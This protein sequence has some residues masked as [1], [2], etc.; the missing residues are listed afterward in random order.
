M[1]EKISVQDFASRIKQKYPQYSEIEDSVLV[2]KMLE[3]YPQYKSTV[4]TKEDSFG[5]TVYKPTKQEGYTI[6]PKKEEAGFFERLGGSAVEKPM[7]LAGS[8]VASTAAQ[9]GEAVEAPFRFAMGSPGVFKSLQSSDPNLKDKIR[10]YRHLYKKRKSEGAPAEELKAIE[11]NLSAIQSDFREKTSSIS[12]D[13]A[14]QGREIGKKIKAVNYTDA[15][16][17]SD[18]VTALEKGDG[19]A[20][21]ESIGSVLLDIG[22]QAT[23]SKLTGGA[24]LYLQGVGETYMESLDELEQRGMSADEAL[25]ETNIMLNSLTTG[26]IIG[27]LESL[28]IESVLGKLNKTFGNRWKNAAAKGI[29]GMLTEAPTEGLQEIAQIVGVTATNLESMNEWDRLKMI[30]KALADPKSTHRVLNSIILGGLGGKV[31][32][33]GAGVL[34]APSKTK[35]EA[36]TDKMSVKEEATE[37]KSDQII[38]DATKLGVV[39]ATP[40]AAEATE[41]VDNTFEQVKEEIKSKPT[42]EYSVEELTKEIEAIEEQTTKESTST[43]PSVRPKE[44]K[45]EIYKERKEEKQTLGKPTKEGLTEEVDVGDIDFGIEVGE[46]LQ[47]LKDERSRLKGEL[48]ELVDLERTADQFLT[49]KEQERVK[50]LKGTISKIEERIGDFKEPKEG[51]LGKPLTETKEAPERPTLKAVEEINSEKGLEFTSNNYERKVKRAL[52]RKTITEEERSSLEGWVK[53]YKEDVAK[54]QKARKPQIEKKIKER[55]ELKKK[56]VKAK[57]IEQYS[58]VSIRKYAKDEKHPK[59]KEANEFLVKQAE[60]KAKKAAEKQSKVVPE[61][62]LGPAEPL[63]QKKK[64]V[65]E[66]GPIE[67]STDAFKTKM[68]T[69]SEHSNEKGTLNI[70]SYFDKAS[71]SMSSDTK[72]DQA[73]TITPEGD[74]VPIDKV[75]SPYLQRIWNLGIGTAQSDS[76]AQSDHHIKEN[77]SNKG[78]VSFVKDEAKNKT[79]SKKIKKYVSGWNKATNS[80]ETINLLEAIGEE[81]GF[82]VKHLEVFFKPALTLSLP[83]GLTDSQVKAK[84]KALTE[85]LEK[86]IE[87][88]PLQKYLDLKPKTSSERNTLKEAKS[89]QTARDQAKGGKLAEATETLRKTT[90]SK[91][92]LEEAQPTLIRE[93]KAAK[94]ELKEAKETE[95]KAQT[96]EVYDKRED[97]RKKYKAIREEEET[98]GKLTDKRDAELTRLEK[99]ETKEAEVST[100]RGFIGTYSEKVEFENAR[101]KEL[102][103]VQDVHTATK[104]VSGKRTTK[105]TKKDVINAIEALNDFLTDRGRRPLSKSDRKNLAETGNLEGDIIRS[106]EEVKEANDKALKTII[107]TS[108]ADKDSKGFKKAQEDSDGAPLE[109]YFPSDDFNNDGFQSRSDQS[110]ASYLGIDTPIK[111]GKQIS[112]AEFIDKYIKNN[113]T[114][115]NVFSS[116]IEIFKNLDK[117]LGR[118]IFILE[119]DDIGG[120][121]G[122]YT[123]SNQG[124]H[125]IAIAKSSIKETGTHEVVHYLTTAIINSKFLENQLLDAGYSKEQLGDIRDIK[126]KVSQ[127]HVEASGVIKQAYDNL[128]KK[129]KN[130]TYFAT[131]LGKINFINEKNALIDSVTE[132][133]YADYLL[134]KSL[135]K[136]IDKYILD[137]KAFIRALVSYSLNQGATG[138]ESYHFTSSVY[139]TT[140]MEEFLAE[141]FSN[142]SFIAI[143]N[144]IG[145]TENTKKTSVY[146]QLM[147]YMLD[148][149]SK[150]TGISRKSL[151]RF[152]EYSFAG[153]VSDTMADYAKIMSKPY[154]ER[155]RAVERI[156]PGYE[157]NRGFLDLLFN[158]AEDSK[159][160]DKMSEEITEN[161][162]KLA[163]LS[164]GKDGKKV[165]LNLERV[166]RLV[167]FIRSNDP[168]FN[169]LVNIV[170]KINETL[171]DSKKITGLEVKSAYKR[172]ISNKKSAAKRKHKTELAKIKL[173]SEI[174]LGQAKDMIAEYIGKKIPSYAGYKRKDILRI[175]N[176]IRLVEDP[177]KF[178][179]YI[180]DI[181]RI[182]TDFKYDKALDNAKKAQNS[183]RTFVRSRLPIPEK[184][185][186]RRFKSVELELLSQKELED[187]KELVRILSF[188]KKKIKNPKELEEWQNII[189]DIKSFM[190]NYEAIKQESLKSEEKSSKD[191]KT[192][193]QLQEESN[194][195]IGKADAERNISM[196]NIGRVHKLAEAKAK[197]VLSNKDLSERTRELIESFINIIKQTSE[198]R[199]L[200]TDDL[201]DYAEGLRYF[202]NYGI[203]TE[204]AGSV[205]SKVEALVRVKDAIHNLKG[206]ELN[207]AKGNFS[208][209]MANANTAAQIVNFMAKMNKKFAQALNNLFFA[210]IRELDSKVYE[211]HRV[212]MNEL[213]ALAND[214]KLKEE[215]LVK[216]QLFRSVFDSAVDTNNPEYLDGINRNI[217]KIRKSLLNLIQ[218]AAENKIDKSVADAKRELSIFNEIISEIQSKGKHQV[219]SNNESIFSGRITEILDAGTNDFEQSVQAFAGQEFKRRHEYSPTKAIGT[220]DNTELGK[221]TTTDIFKNILQGNVEKISELE[222]G[223]ARH[224][225][226]DVGGAYY[227]NNIMNVMNKYILQSNYDA[228]ALS[229]ILVLNKIMRDQ[230]IKDKIGSENIRIIKESLISAVTRGRGNFESRAKWANALEAGKNLFVVGRMGTVFQL[231]TQLLT[232]IPAIALNNPKGF[233]RASK[234]MMDHFI[235]NKPLN[236]PGHPDVKTLKDWIKKFGHGLQNRD[237]MF[238]RFETMSDY[239]RAKQGYKKW[240]KKAED[241]TTFVLKNSDAMAATWTFM[242]SYFENGGT[243]ENPNKKKISAAEL[244]TDM[245][246]NISNPRFTSE[247]FKPNSNS[248]RVLLS[249]MYTFKSFALNQSLNTLYSLRN[250]KDPAARRLA[251]ANMSNIVLYHMM[252]MILSHGLGQLMGA[253]GD[254]DDEK[255]ADSRSEMIMNNFWQKVAA[256]AVFDVGV[257]WMPEIAEE[258]VKGRTDK[259]I[260]KLKEVVT[261]K[262]LVDKNER[263]FFQSSGGP[264]KHMGGYSGMFEPLT[265]V[266][267]DALKI[268]SGEEIDMY[269]FWLSTMAEATSFMRA[270]PFRGDLA[271]LLRTQASIE[272]QKAKADGNRWFKNANKKQENTYKKFKKKNKWN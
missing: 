262:D 204:K 81:L 119:A 211:K 193:E 268:A 201:V 180:D 213:G 41:E 1:P 256:R 167:K 97:V 93:L 264:E 50:E 26:L 212:L 52:A 11:N 210:K 25:G 12:N 20:V 126:Q 232:T 113:V 254:D 47:S 158:K 3:K 216:I 240:S 58:I 144:T 136:D 200:S 107:R 121:H 54:R 88:N 176:Q 222:S 267:D 131:T 70:N 192:P 110:K 231:S 206:A 148:A 239:S 166:K 91:M 172:N 202:S 105:A 76:G 195:K 155:I 153:E 183:I 101:Q 68:P 226:A 151:D 248:H 2:S 154:S 134:D 87:V 123:V 224:K 35:P 120:S 117:V 92:G 145:K 228:S 42:K 243:L 165:K 61:D 44:E 272:K 251:A 184:G 75:L 271:R 255:K 203:L 152:F 227:D 214:L 223:F 191:K 103:K 5:L 14:R 246:Q 32:G 140:N 218:A 106:E 205:I 252:S 99:E 182:V 124:N 18:I 31:V 24:A 199:K 142:P 62:D 253:F 238:E 162:A 109:D 233:M 48:K 188:G 168:S 174:D 8:T 65:P 95:R 234:V 181:N 242:S 138:R 29:K 72:T 149:A 235:G 85:A 94:K 225:G 186:W 156:N 257:T 150:L 22:F 49:V 53:E 74:K 39:E 118:K 59:Y 57:P 77:R 215:N 266:T 217:K 265:K 45:K 179:T 260:I 79:F 98:K 108:K 114:D 82:N 122:F 208:K 4:Q 185:L 249:L 137:R 241:A 147:D 229:E 96:K 56:E 219:L 13:M 194:A 60:E 133:V 270:M 146:K 10:R 84:W 21:A 196:V 55:K 189:E 43:T 115:N 33:A 100:R 28:G 160:T 247:L 244:D 161:A 9:T 37:A 159:D 190:T 250:A 178:K 220:I 34:Q 89:I 7:S 73:E 169:E 111:N 171:P 16:L 51:K 236:I 197:K 263:L 78:Y 125:Y 46:T 177:K 135:L 175:L 164:F 6:Q 130:Y 173:Y 187:Y 19:A 132:N 66:K 261:G 102:D 258:W 23:A 90:V 104:A 269:A 128:Y 245:L 67:A 139:G 230:S 80:K 209:M 38:T 69:I 27:K 207:R 40:E 112:I 198:L 143:L 259:A 30:S 86:N 83:S 221:G 163:Q 15:R 237:V 141:S 127:L 116:F 170:S 129:I 157:K 36:K 63:Y 64:K 17:K 71:E